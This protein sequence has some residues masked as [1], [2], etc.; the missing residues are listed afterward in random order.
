MIGFELDTD[1]YAARAREVAETLSNAQHLEFAGLAHAAPISHPDQIWPP[2]R[3]LPS[4]TPPDMTD[5]TVT[6]FR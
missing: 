3:R 4:P 5:I 6:G 1:T 2:G